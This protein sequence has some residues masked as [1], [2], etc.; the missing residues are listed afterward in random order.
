MPI[1]DPIRGNKVAPASLAF[2][3]GTAGSSMISA[4]FQ[5]IVNE[6]VV[7]ELVY[8]GASLREVQ[9]RLEHAQSNVMDAERRA[10]SHT[11]SYGQCFQWDIATDITLLFP[12][13]GPVPFSNE[14]VRSPGA[15]YMDTPV[16]WIHRIP[17]GDQGT[18]L[19]GAYIQISFVA[20]QQV[21][22]L[23]LQ[24]WK[25]GA[26]HKTLCEHDADYSGDGM[27]MRDAVLFGALPIV[28]DIGDYMDIRLM[29]TQDSA[30]GTDTFIHPSSI[31]GYV[32]GWFATVRAGTDLPT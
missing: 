28:M 17:K 26:H 2:E 7:T 18:W 4:S 25:N 8:G 15:M 9:A 31:H 20:L 13:T 29:T 11:G 21:R 1:N 22:T 12:Q 19:Y 32:W 27:Y 23:A 3:R 30:P 6:A 16:Q 10:K 5:T 14:V 24:I